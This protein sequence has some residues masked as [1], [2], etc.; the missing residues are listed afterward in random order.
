MHAT[1]LLAASST[2]KTSNGLKS[3]LHPVTLTLILLPP[4]STFK[5]F[6]DNTG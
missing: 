4:A 5:D 2:F 3:F 6:G 1:Q